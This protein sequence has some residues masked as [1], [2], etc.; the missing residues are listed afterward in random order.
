MESERFAPLRMAGVEGHV[1]AVLTADNLL[2]ERSDGKGMKIDLESISRIRHHHVAITPPL[3]TLFGVLSILAGY[4]VFTGQVQI[5][6][7]ALGVAA[8]LVWIVG[9][10]PALSIDSKQ[11]DR[12]ILHGR[13]HLLQRMYI[14]ID[15][16]SDGATLNE[17]VIGLEELQTLG[18]ASLG[19]I[20]E[21]RNQ[22]GEVATAESLLLQAPVDEETLEMA[23]A[24]LHAG[25][26]VISTAGLPTSSAGGAPD[27]TLTAD[28]QE[29]GIVTPSAGVES[30]DIPRSVPP[31]TSSVVADSMI[32][33]SSTAL[34]EQRQEMVTPP[35]NYN[36]PFQPSIYPDQSAAY[37]DQ[38]A[39]SSPSGTMNSEPTVVNRAAAAAQEASSAAFGFGGCDMFSLFDELDNVTPSSPNPG[40]PPVA[41]HTADGVTSHSPTHGAG[42]AFS[43]AHQT[44]VGPGWKRPS[45]TH[46]T[47]YAM[48]TAA[49]GPNLPEPTNIALR[50]DLPQT[51]GLVASAIVGEDVEKLAPPLPEVLSKAIA[52]VTEPHPLKDYPALRRLHRQFARSGLLRPTPPPRRRSSAVKTIGEWVRPGIGMVSRRIGRPVVTGAG[53]GYH[54]VYGDEDGNPND[55]YNESNLHSTQILRLRADQDSQSEIHE[56]LR[57]LTMNGGGAIADDLANRTLRGISS[58]CESTPLSLGSKGKEASIPPGSFECMVSSNEPTA[59]IAGMKRLG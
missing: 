55:E 39:T 21:M 32:R 51:S 35:A 4:R 18:L 52:R 8:L 27:V 17:A 25:R 46:S 43:T 12:H 36:S 37:P 9:R 13:D 1:S 10:R 54:T 57:L 41:Q 45:E 49:A 11:G 42:E 56:R 48:I 16:M 38:S 30:S 7:F 3:L 23:L 5:Y 20:A 2:L 28:Q 6:S 22:V 24:N 40:L 53:D 29:R 26:A 59:R 14:I 44:P 33:R 47:S 15:R 50:G 34:A 31:L 58:G 19:N